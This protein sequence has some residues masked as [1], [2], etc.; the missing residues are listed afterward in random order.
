MSTATNRVLAA[1]FVPHVLI[2]A[3][4]ASVPLYVP[5]W[6]GEFGVSRATIGLALGAL[7]V[8]YGGTAIPAGVLSD[9]IGASRFIEVFLLGTAVAAVVVSRADSFAALVAALVVLGL[10]TGLYHA[11][12]FSLLSRQE[13]ASS[14]LFAY[15]NVGGHVGLGFGPLVMAVLLAFTDWRTAL[16]LAAVPFAL[17][18]VVFRV[19]A[20]TDD[21]PGAG[22]ETARR[23][24]GGLLASATG[25]PLRTQLR[26]L[27]TVGFVF[28]LA[29]YLLRGTY[30]R[31]SIVFLPDFLDAAA[32]L[33]PIAILGKDVPPGQWVYSA[34]LMVGTVGQVL[35]GKLGDRFPEERILVVQLLSTAG[36]LVLLGRTSG[37]ALFAVVGLFGLMMYSFPPILQT[38]VA[39]YTPERNRGL[40]FG[41][42]TAVNAA[43]GGF[44]GS[45]LAGWLATVGTYADMFATIA[46][47]PLA[48][49]VLILGYLWRF[50]GRE[51]RTLC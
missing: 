19:V 42:T 37:I 47:V 9:R 30:Y 43:A 26:R 24:D 14:S 48:A 34:M 13:N 46:V 45:A 27:C 39:A 44:L 17:T 31:G 4:V 38:L 22:G 1:T 21:P 33:A 7:F 50:E 12:A 11:P 49:L 36:L 6:L 5:L 8:F 15:H 23:A 41:V 18:W 28:V 3:L 16:L 10:S 25:G 35:G 20:P 2:H 29:V 51:S 32:S 40:G